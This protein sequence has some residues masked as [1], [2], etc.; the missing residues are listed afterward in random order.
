[1][2]KIVVI[3]YVVCFGFYVLLPRQ[4]DYFDGEVTSAVIV[5]NNDSLLAEYTDG[6]Q[7]HYATVKYP[8]MYNEGEKVKVIYELSDHSKGSVYE[9]WGYWIQFGELIASLVVVVV[10][11][12]VS[13][14]LTSNPT[15]EALLEELEGSRVKPRKPKY[16]L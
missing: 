9:L 12:G 6:K 2:I 8:F 3:L 15:P 13:V 16:D 4:P 10:L 5:K 7:M 11:Y 14:T 1:L